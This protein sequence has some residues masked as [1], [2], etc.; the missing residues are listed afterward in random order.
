MVLRT[1]FDSP[2]TLNNSSIFIQIRVE[3]Q[4]EGQHIQWN[5]E[6]PVTQIL[7]IVK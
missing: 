2:P 1:C 6:A 5:D 4:E 3:Q 7:L